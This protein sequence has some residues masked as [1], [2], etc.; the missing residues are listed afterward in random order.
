MQPPRQMEEPGVARKAP[1]GAGYGRTIGF[2]PSAW[3][4][5]FGTRNRRRGAIFNPNILRL[6]L[7]W[8]GFPS[9][10]RDPRSLPANEAIQH[11]LFFGLFC[12]RHWS[13]LKWLG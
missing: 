3:A 6:S 13:S 7:R 12:R 11:R 1:A 10:L 9:G 5:A 4:R 2:F 8:P